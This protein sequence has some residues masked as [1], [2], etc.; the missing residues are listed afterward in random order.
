MTYVDKVEL[1]EPDRARVNL[2]ANIVVDALAPTNG[3]LTNPTALK[4]LVDTGGQSLVSG[5]QNYIERSRQ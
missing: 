5:L 1:S 3:L 4:K 2:I